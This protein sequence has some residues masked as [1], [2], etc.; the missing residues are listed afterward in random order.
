[1]KHLPLT[2][3]ALAVFLVSAGCGTTGKDFNEAGFQK[4]VNG[5]TT[6]QELKYLF[7]PP[8]KTGVQNGRETWTYEFNEYRLFGSNR[9]KD[10]SIVFNPDG[11]VKSHQFMTN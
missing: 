1:M 11:T 3:M 9:T 7:G 6:K 4:I 5:T 2:V 8:F 10:I